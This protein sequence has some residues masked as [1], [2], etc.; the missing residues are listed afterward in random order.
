M[1]HYTQKSPPLTILVSSYHCDVSTQA[2]L[3]S[4]CMHFLFVCARAGVRDFTWRARD[5]ELLFANKACYVT[6]R[7]STIRNMSPWMR[8]YTVRFFEFEY[9][10]IGYLYQLS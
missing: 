10:I 8:G 6:A 4:A 9:Y 2:Q 1:V 5:L 3:V 7:R